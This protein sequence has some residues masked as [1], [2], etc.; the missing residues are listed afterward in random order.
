MP[1]A[2]ATLTPTPA[3]TTTTATPGPSRQVES[4]AGS[5]SQKVRAFREAVEAKDTGAMLR[6]Q[7]ELL[8]EVD[9]AEGSI[10]EDRSQFAERLRSAI[11][12]IREGATGDAGKLD[13]AARELREATGKPEEDDRARDQGTRTPGLSQTE[14]RS[15]AESLAR[16]V[17]SF[18]DARRSRSAENTLRQQKE[19]LEE[20]NR[21]E[22]AIKND[23]TRRGEQIRSAL[24]SIRNGLGSEDSKLDEARQ[25]LRKA[26]ED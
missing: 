10:K 3:S 13:A 21:V 24:Q 16:R 11:R 4:A 9:K 1:T 14:L 17:E 2:K 18:D 8:E 5:L 15:M 7:R 25:A 6:L 20:I 19:L 12:S 22:Q 23:N 26:L